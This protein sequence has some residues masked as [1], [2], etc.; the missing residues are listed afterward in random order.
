MLI[1][2]CRSSI[3]QEGTNQ[4]FETIEK[5]PGDEMVYPD[6]KWT[7]ASP[8]NFGYS[9]E[10]LNLVKESFEEVGGDAM[11]IVKNGYVIASFGDTK[12]NIPNFSIRKSFLNSLL[13]MEYDKGNLS[14]NATLNSLGITDRDELS[15]NEKKATIEHLLTSTSGVYHPANHESSRQKEDRP[16]RESKKPGEFFYYNNWDFNALGSIYMQITGNDLFEAFKTNISDQIGMQDF[17]LQNTKYEN[18]SASKHPAYTF[19]SS[20]RDDARFGLLYLNGGKWKGESIIS[21]E[22]IDESLSLKTTT[23]EAWYYDYGYL[24]WIDSK[25]NQFMA[26]GKSGQYIALIP[27]ENMVIVFRADPGSIIKK[28]MG[29][30]VKPQ[31]SFMLIDEVLRAKQ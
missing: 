5:S 18:G 28:W 24:W 1:C 7:Y 30:R 10:L 17:N 27:D 23:G 31:Q 14:M 29:S 12:L 11:I 9:I 3:S 21:S 20:A 26:R 15:T 4:F 25:N 19:E 8:E 2:S 6:E 13:G 16:P 22:W